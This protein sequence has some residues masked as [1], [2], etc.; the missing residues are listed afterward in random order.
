M[1]AHPYI[2]LP[3]LIN[4]RFQFLFHSPSGV[5]FTFPSRYLFTIG[6]QV[7]FSFT[8]WSGQIPTEFHVLHSTWENNNQ[9]KST[10]H[11]QDCHLLWSFFPECSATLRK[12]AQD[13]HLLEIT[14]LFPH[15]ATRV[16]LHSTSFKLFPFRSPLLRESHS[17]SL[18]SGT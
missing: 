3:P 6:H 2:V 18:P 4:I 14:S 10:F 5:L 16:S 11:I 7:V 15:T 13:Q 1:V 12:L 9:L 8:L 17:F